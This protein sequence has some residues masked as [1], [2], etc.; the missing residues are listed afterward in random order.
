MVLVGWRRK[1]EGICWRERGEGGFCWDG[2][3]GERGGEGRGGGGGGEERGYC[4]EK[5]EIKR[6]GTVRRKRR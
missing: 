2:R 5:E 3:S 4:R 1:V 6:G